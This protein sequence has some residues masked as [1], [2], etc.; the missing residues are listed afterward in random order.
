MT[1]VNNFLKF[2]QVLCVLDNQ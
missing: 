1:I 2:S